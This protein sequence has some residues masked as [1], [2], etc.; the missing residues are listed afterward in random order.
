MGTSA[1]SCRVVF[2]VAECR[3]FVGGGQA[4]VSGLLLH[5]PLRAR[6]QWNQSSRKFCERQLASVSGALAVHSKSRRI[7][8]TSAATRRLIPAAGAF[9][10]GAPRR[11][12][13]TTLERRGRPFSEGPRTQAQGARSGPRIGLSRSS[14]STRD[15]EGDVHADHSKSPSTLVTATMSGLTG[16]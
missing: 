14:R 11:R 10:R 7:I 9:S 13:P 6:V 3:R 15:D 4:R 1:A 8:T 12:L 2:M 5:A 16:R